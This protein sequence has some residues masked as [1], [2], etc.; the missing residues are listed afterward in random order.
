MADEAFCLG[1][2]RVYG[3]KVG[4]LTE[5]N[6]LAHHLTFEL[7]SDEE[8]AQRIRKWLKNG[9]DRKCICFC[10]LKKC[11]KCVFVTLFGPGKAVA[12]D[13]IA[14]MRTLYLARRHSSSESGYSDFD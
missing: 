12:H 5:E 1:R 7:E 4:S 2:W 14:L 11:V 13:D 6:L 10:R 3:K 9:K 8:F